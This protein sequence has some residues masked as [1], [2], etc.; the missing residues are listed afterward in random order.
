MVVLRGVNE[1]EVG[2][3]MKFSAS[4]GVVLQLIEL[5]RTPETSDAYRRYH[6]DLGPIER[7]LRERATGVRTRRLMHARRK[8]IVDGAE[9]EVVNP[10]HNSD[11]C[12]GCTRLRLTSDGHLK[13]CLMR[14]DNLVDVL[15]PLRSGDLAVAREDFVRAMSLREP[16]CGPLVVSP[17]H[18]RAEIRPRLARAPAAR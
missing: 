9:V 12:V 10:M 17:S 18:T 4:R 2:R 16:Y 13:P 1:A 11:F 14:N 6:R 3:M 5:L 15:T 7:M 8:Y